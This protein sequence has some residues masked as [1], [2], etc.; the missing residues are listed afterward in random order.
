MSLGAN[1]TRHEH[2]INYDRAKKSEEDR[3]KLGS[4]SFILKYVLNLL[5]QPILLTLL[6]PYT[7]RPPEPPQTKSQP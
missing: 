5:G 1:C 3:A 7:N 4:L 6:R 2:S